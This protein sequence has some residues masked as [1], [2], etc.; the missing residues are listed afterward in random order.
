[1][2]SAG[3]LVDSRDNTGVFVQYQGRFG[4]HHLQASVRNDDNEQFGKFRVSGKDAKNIEPFIH[5]GLG[6]AFMALNDSGLEITDG[7]A[8]R[9][10]AIVGAGIG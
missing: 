3:Y 5:Y 2:S 7:N 1:G 10:G 4:A 8:E 6:A 9:I